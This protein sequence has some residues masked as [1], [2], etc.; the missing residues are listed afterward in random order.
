MK[1]TY[2]S[3]FKAQVVLELLKDTTPISQIAAAYEVHPTVLRAWR[4]QAVKELPTVFETRDS[5]TDAQVAPAKHLAER[6]A[7][8]GRR[9]THVNFLKKRLPS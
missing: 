7:E 5:L 3:A 9:T 4:D 1:K 2:R 8:I 6:S